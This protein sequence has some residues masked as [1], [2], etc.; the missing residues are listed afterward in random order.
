[1]ATRLSAIFEWL[2][3]FF[4]GSTIDKRMGVVRK[5][6]WDASDELML[7]LFGDYL[8]LPN[9]ASYYMLELL[10]MV[11]EDLPAWQRRMQ[12]RRMLVC[13]K[14]AHYGFDG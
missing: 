5:E 13:E 3:M 11:A 6:A 10:P 7:L 2:R 8:G 9:P 1:M 12:N 14:A 4:Y